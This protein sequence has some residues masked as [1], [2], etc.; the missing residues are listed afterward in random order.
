MMNVSN[1]GGVGPCIG[2]DAF[3]VGPEVFS[4]SSNP[5]ARDVSPGRRKDTPIS[6][7]AS[8]SSLLNWVAGDRIDIPG[9][10][11][12]GLLHRREHGVREGGVDL[13]PATVEQVRECRV[14]SEAT[15]PASPPFRRYPPPRQTRTGRFVGRTSRHEPP[16]PASPNS[17]DDA[18][19][20]VNA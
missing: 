7:A 12:G 9:P 20:V 5:S 11:T 13:S 4:S 14:E 18:R 15:N 2:I 17:T 8:A 1:R 19:G 6:A 10:R 3:E 16:T